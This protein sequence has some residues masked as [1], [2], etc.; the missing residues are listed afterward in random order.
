MSDAY[1]TKYIDK[2]GRTYRVDF[3]YD[4]DAEAPWDF[5][6][7]HGPVS[8]WTTRDKQPGELVLCTDRNMKRYYHFQLAMQEARAGWGF[9]TGEEAQRAVMRDYEYLRKWCNDIWYY[10][11]IKVTAL[12]EN[13]GAVEDGPDASVWGIESEGAYD[14]YKEAQAY[15][16]EVINDLIYEVNVQLEKAEYPVATMGV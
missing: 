6:D 12:T 9:K 2:N 5:C 3:Y 14:T 13:D 8:D 16:E 7:G 15:Y 10:I 4:S 1:N 11:G